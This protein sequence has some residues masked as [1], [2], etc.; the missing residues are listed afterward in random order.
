[1][2]RSWR[3]WAGVAIT[4]LLV[5]YALRGQDFGEMRRALRQFN[6]WYL[7]PAIA[8][9]FIGVWFRAVRWR[10]LLKP[11]VPVSTRDVLPV[12]IIGFM[13]NNLLPF[14][15]GE[16]ARSYALSRKTGARKTAALAT[17][18]VERLFDGIT[19][20]GFILGAATVVSL[21]SDL[22]HVALIAF[23]V[24]TAGILVLTLLTVG[25]DWRDRLL[26][27]VLGPLPTSLADRVERMAESFLAGLG[28][29][30]RR[31]DLAAVAG[32][33]LLAW[34]FEAS[35]Y[36]V[37][38]RG[39]ADPLPEKM[40]PAATML[41][42]GV[43]NLA[44]L[45]PSSPGYVGPFETG[46]KLVVDGALGVNS[47][48]ALSYAFLVHA[49]LFFPVTIIGLFVTWRERISFSQLRDADDSIDPAEPTQGAAPISR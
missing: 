42:T 12:V 26:Q 11:V 20:L 1:M 36:W 3:F 48:L 29:L 6:Y 25:G 28:V 4:V 46:V 35:M 2:R 24:F 43:A 9:Y 38:A 8:L 19:M 18:A 41:T 47:A 45:I 31:A 33:S 23:I 17:I 15:A 13:A 37:I 34:A 7:V 5:G 40:T 14:R 32:C 22:R 27:I 30:R 21:T 39:F 10:I 44:T 16:I 49:A